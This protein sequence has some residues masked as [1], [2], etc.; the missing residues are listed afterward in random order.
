MRAL[1]D[2]TAMIELLSSGTT[3]GEL[4][5]VSERRLEALYA[6]GHTLYTQGKY[7]DAAPVFGF[8]VTH[9]HLDRRF[10]KA[11]GACL[12][13][14]G[15][16]ADALKYYGVA[17]LL[18]LTDPD[19]VVHTAECLLALSR[20]EEAARALRFALGQIKG[21]EKHAALGERVKALLELSAHKRDNIRAP[22]PPSIP[23]S[24]A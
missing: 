1:Q 9:S 3:L 21:E 19:P 17:S 2:A 8:L 6:V 16:H 18:D 20:D 4:H 23:S 22:S 5:G 24:P 15:R 10:H 13:K 12:Q 14:L 11:F 7:A